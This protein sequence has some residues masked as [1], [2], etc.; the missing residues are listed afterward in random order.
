MQALR[1]HPNEH[2]LAFRDR[3]MECAR[4]AYNS[5]DLSHRQS[6][7]I[8]A[9]I[10]ALP[11]RNLQLDLLRKNFSTLKDLVQEH[12]QFYLAE[13]SLASTDQPFQLAQPAPQSKRVHFAEDNTAQLQTQLQDLAKQLNHLNINLI[14]N[15]S[16]AYTYP[17]LHSDN[18][19]QYHSQ[20]RRNFNNRRDDYYTPNWRERSL[21]PYRPHYENVPEERP[22][23]QYMRDRGT[24]SQYR[25]RHQ[26][27]AYPPGEQQWHPRRSRSPT[28]WF[29][30]RHTFPAAPHSQ[31]YGN[32]PRA[33]PIYP[34]SRDAEQYW[35][36]R[37]AYSHY[38]HSPYYSDPSTFRSSY[39]RPQDG[40]RPQQALNYFQYETMTP[41]PPQYPYQPPY[42]PI[43][44]NQYQTPPQQITPTYHPGQQPLMPPRTCSPQKR[45]RPE[46]PPNDTHMDATSLQPLKPILH[47]RRRSISPVTVTGIQQIHGPVSHPSSLYPEIQIAE[48]SLN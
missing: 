25:G 41:F 10:N 18:F 16:E 2:P 48:K 7:L 21:S 5:D 27:P 30:H 39:H 32:G 23:Y 4:L 31:H 22:P 26:G 15:R 45:P 33:P 29:N 11:D 8:A 28:P 43:Y 47:A 14:N 3:L 40:Q 37:P 1:F 13:H 6:D 44:Q 20:D 36:R 42:Q 38:Q 19:R 24:T 34:R 17:D 12:V 46:D 9:Y 35:G